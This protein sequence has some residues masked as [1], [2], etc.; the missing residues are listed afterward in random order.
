MSERPSSDLDPEML[1]L[2]GAIVVKWSYVELFVSDLF[3]SLTNGIPFAM[4]VV[5]SNTS[6]STLSSWIRTLLDHSEGDHEWINNVLETLTEID[7][8]RQERNSIVHGHWMAGD[9]PDCAISTTTSLKRNE[10]IKDALITTA[11][12]KALLDSINDVA[13]RLRTLL[14]ACGAH[15]A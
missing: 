13:T 1:R 11:D 9:L 15:S 4:H 6:Q 14:V 5:T 12:L 7:D 8:I 3:V 10:L 2:I